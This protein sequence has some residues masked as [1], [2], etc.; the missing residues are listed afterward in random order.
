MLTLIFYM[1]NYAM[2]II[3]LQHK[4]NTVIYK[5]MP[6]SSLFTTITTTSNDD[7]S[8]ANGYKYIYLYFPT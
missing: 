6:P 5:R 3:I 4:N 8:I 2:D 7:Y 1:S